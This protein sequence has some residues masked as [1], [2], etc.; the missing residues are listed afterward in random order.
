M[1]ISVSI[2]A[3]IDP[4][5][6]EASAR[7][8]IEIGQLQPIAVLMKEGGRFD[9]IFGKGRV[10]A[11][12][13]AGRTHIKAD[14]YQGLT[15]PQRLNSRI[16]SENERREPAHPLYKA[17]VLKG[18]WDTGEFKTQGELAQE[19]GMSGGML[20]DYL[21]FLE[22]P[23]E[24]LQIFSALKISFY[25]LQAVKSLKEEGQLQIAQE[26]KDGTLKPQDVVQECKKLGGDQKKNQKKQPDAPLDP[27]TGVW[28][29]AKTDM[30]L[31]A[32]AF[33]KVAY[34]PLT[35][36]RGRKVNAWTLT[37]GIDKPNVRAEL[38]VWLQKI[39]DLVVAGVDAK[40]LKH[41]SAKSA[42]VAQVEKLN[43]KIRSDHGIAAPKELPEITFRMMPANT[44]NGCANDGF[45][46]V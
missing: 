5:E 46:A 39:T 43:A 29:L 30:D 10:L 38:T 37:V 6:I 41:A 27:L 40:D 32:R 36:E 7:N 16:Y 11:A 18:M 33:W 12:H 1:I 20:S 13:K 45:G 17:R 42:E 4:Q 25:A 44:R 21:S 2:P 31:A 34:G 26:L 24:A 3:S 15:V 22:F 8:Q 9:V 35:I 28:T 23:S 14:I 19:Q